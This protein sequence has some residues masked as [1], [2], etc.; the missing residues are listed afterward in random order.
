MI[1]V[2]NNLSELAYLKDSWDYLFKVCSYAT[3][4]QRYEY[5]FNSWK[6]IKHDG[7]ELYILC[8]KSDNTRQVTAIFPTSLDN[9]GI[10]SFIT[11][12]YID[13]CSALVLPE[14]DNYLLYEEIATFIKKDNKIKAISFIDLK[15]DNPL[16]AVLKPHFTNIILKECSYYSTLPIVKHPNDR[17]FVDGIRSVNS[18]G[19]KNIR[20]VR[21]KL[22]GKSEFRLLR[23]SDNNSYPDDIISKLCKQM[24]QTGLRTEQYLSNN[25]RLFWKDLYESSLLTIATL[26][27]DGEI[28]SCNFMYYDIKRNEYIKWIM[29]YTETKWNMC[30]N[31]LIAEKLYNDGDCTINFA[32]GIYD[33]KMVNFHP[34]VKVLLSLSVFKS[35]RQKFLFL[36]KDFVRQLKHL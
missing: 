8:V 12:A 14:Y 2:I 23:H 1:N 26:S 3:P 9:H 13:F 22:E 18:H 29:L 33:Y 30:I 35:K 36:L 31:T 15:T 21:K 28:K 4:F 27:F 16:I 32:R 17:D 20:V 11:Q 10:L 6:R 19:R 5:V 24:I 34:S 7:D 25:M